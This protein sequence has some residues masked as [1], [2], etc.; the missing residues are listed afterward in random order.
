M[1]D[2]GEVYRAVDLTPAQQQDIV[3]LKEKGLI[4]FT[5]CFEVCSYV[6]GDPG[7]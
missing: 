2:F 1:V 4:Y 5:P 3:S 7:G 6:K